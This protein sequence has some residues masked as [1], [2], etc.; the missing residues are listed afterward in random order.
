MIGDSCYVGY[1]A[2]SRTFS[3]DNNGTTLQAA[4]GSSK[5]LSNGQCSLNVKQA[6]VSGSGNTL[7]I[8]F[9]ITFSSTYLGSKS[10][11]SWVADANS[12]S[13][14]KQAGSFTVK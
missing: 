6:K 12:W 8:T 2:P 7:T 13:G 3:L 4:S 1:W 5:T 10:I 14:W 9:P 11:V